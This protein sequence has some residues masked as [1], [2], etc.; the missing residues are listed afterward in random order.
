MHCIAQGVAKSW[1]L[2]SNFHIAFILPQQNIL[3]IWRLFSSIS[4]QCFHSDGFWSNFMCKRLIRALI[5][6]AVMFSWQEIIYLRLFKGVDEICREDDRWGLEWIMNQ[7]L[8]VRKHFLLFALQSVTHSTL[9]SQ[10]RFS[11]KIFE[12][13][14][15]NLTKLQVEG[16][17]W[18]LHGIRM[19]ITIP[20][21]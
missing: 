9:S 7:N 17:R 19:K 18:I 5:F 16:T 13:F 4:V 21:P 14:F 8:T 11:K 15:E 20:Y 1:T 6:L 10:V 3:C 2:L 12:I